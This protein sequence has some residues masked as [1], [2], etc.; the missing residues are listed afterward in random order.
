MVGSS[1]ATTARNDL[2]VASIQRRAARCE[3]ACCGRTSQNH[4][5]S[6]DLREHPRFRLALGVT[7]RLPEGDVA[8]TTTGMS[9]GGMSLVLPVTP[10][11]NAIFD[12]EISLPDGRRIHAKA[13]CRTVRADGHV[14]VSLSLTP[15]DKALWERLVDEEETTG[16]LWR[17]IGRIADA[18]DDA[19]AP[20]GKT[21][22]ATPTEGT[23]RFHTAGENGLAWRMAFQRH[24]SDPAA[25]SDLCVTLPGFR[26]PARRAVRRVL[27]QDVTLQLDPSLPPCAVRIVE[28]NRGGYACVQ[29]D[30][31]AL[32]SLGVG[33]LFLVEE[34]GRSVFPHFT[35]LELEQ[36]ACDTFRHDLSRPVFS[37]KAPD[38][39]PPVELPP[40]ITSATVAT[41]AMTTATDTTSVRPAAADSRRFR[42]GYDAVRFAQT[43]SEDVQRRRYG[44]HDIYFHPSVW[45][46]V[47]VDGSELMGPTLQDEGRI[48]VLALVGPGAPKVVRLSTQSTV[49]LLKPPQGR[50]QRRSP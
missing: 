49:S 14:G 13:R 7:A 12:V 24:P 46:R 31:V 2:A 45:A 23:R 15:T 3:V 11:L 21:V 36:I 38:T 34:D 47:V 42:E 6:E 26:E 32:V 44:D 25:E 39:P 1:T 22:A 16:G 9:R 48:C 37:A 43:A 20:R 18:P 8:T 5:V 41:T 33:E 30:P 50:S 28:L 27:R 35:P 10:P 4:R 19:L 29:H 40:L 17:M